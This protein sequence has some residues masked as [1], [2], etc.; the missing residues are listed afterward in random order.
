[1]D[2]LTTNQV[3]ELLEAVR[4]AFGQSPGPEDAWT[5][6]E[7]EERMGWSHTLAALKVRQLVRSGKWEHVRVAR[8]MINGIPRQTDAYRPV[9]G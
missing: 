1:M 2:D 4:T 6:Q 9:R 3:D 7:I 5:R 8:T